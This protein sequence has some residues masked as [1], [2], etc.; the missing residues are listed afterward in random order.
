[1][2]IE[3]TLTTDEVRINYIGTTP[4]LAADKPWMEHRPAEFDRWL[5]EY[6]RQQREEAWDDGYEAR[7]EEESSVR[8]EYGMEFSDTAENPY[9]RTES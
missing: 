6:T 9:R 8:L 4:E 7:G 3:Y 5:A 1:M 2:T